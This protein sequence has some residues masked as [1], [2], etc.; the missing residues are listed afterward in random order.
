MLCIVMKCFV[1]E[2]FLNSN[3]FFPEAA[4]ITTASSATSLSKS[5]LK[6]S[7]NSSVIAGKNYLW[8]LQNPCPHGPSPNWT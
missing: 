8:R 7:V 5:Q 1:H 3:L 4:A 6:P 2:P